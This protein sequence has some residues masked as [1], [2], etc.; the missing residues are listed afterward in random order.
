[1]LLVH[2][3]HNTGQ[4][5]V[6]FGKNM[7]LQLQFPQKTSR[8]AALI[9]RLEILKDTMNYRKLKLRH[10]PA[11]DETQLGQRTLGTG[12]ASTVA[13]EPGSTGRK[14]GTCNSSVPALTSDL[15]YYP[16]PTPQGDL[17]PIPIH[18]RNDGPGGNV[19]HQN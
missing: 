2:K 1:M 19:W 18:S 4:K 12:S 17:H 7:E 9:Y 11:S 10:T 14:A 3:L 8:L 6:V 16:L 15:V 13:A 5:V